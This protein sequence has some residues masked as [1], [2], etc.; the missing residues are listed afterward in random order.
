MDKLHIN[1]STEI[2][3]PGEISDFVLWPV[4]TERLGGDDSAIAHLRLTV[5]SIVLVIYFLELP[6]TYVI[7]GGVSLF[8]IYF[9]KL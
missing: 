7:A 3:D 1:K 6:V 9:V 5:G 2:G 8:H 4:G